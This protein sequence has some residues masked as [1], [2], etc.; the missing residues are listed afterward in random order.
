VAARSEGEPVGRSTASFD[1]TRFLAR[2]VYL[3][4]TLHGSG[5]IDAVY[6][7]AGAAGGQS[8]YW[9]VLETNAP[10]LRV[11]DKVAS[12]SGHVVH[13]LALRIGPLAALL[14][15]ESTF[16]MYHSSFRSESERWRKPRCR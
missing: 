13:A 16:S 7:H 10:A 8:V 5:L 6:A 1:V 11:C 12:R 9:H 14:P 4:A 3:Q 15:Q 2:G